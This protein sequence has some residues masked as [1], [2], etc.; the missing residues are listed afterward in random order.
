MGFSVH[1]TATAGSPKWAQLGHQ[2]RAS[3][4][5]S[6]GPAGVFVYHVLINDNKGTAAVLNYLGVRGEW[7]HST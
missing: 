4:I 1:L 3:V 5:F 2:V 6:R 7:G